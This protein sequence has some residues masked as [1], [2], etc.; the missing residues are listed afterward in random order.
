MRTTRTDQSIAVQSREFPAEPSALADV[1]AFL[2][3]RLREGGIAG[4]ASDDVVLAVS[5]ACAN[6]VLH[7]GSVR[8]RV[9]WQQRGARVEIRIRDEGRFRR[10]TPDAGRYG[11]NG[12][13]LMTAVMDEVSVRRGTARR[14]GTEVRLV[15]VLEGALPL[16]PRRRATRVEAR[17][18]L[19]SR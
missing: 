12:L 13:P 7:S 14:P 4:T 10:T 16:R 17:R 11:G 18:Q 15:K 6:A 9:T 5:E 1:R 8:F 3:E 2:R 19:I